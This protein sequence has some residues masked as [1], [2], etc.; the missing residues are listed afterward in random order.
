MLFLFS[1]AAKGQ[2]VKGLNIHSAPF[3]AD[4]FCVYSFFYKQFTPFGVNRTFHLLSES[5]KRLKYNT[6]AFKKKILKIIAGFGIIF[7]RNDTMITKNWVY[8]VKYLYH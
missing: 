6:I 5:S 3:G 8:F 7:Y 1:F 4:E 2:N